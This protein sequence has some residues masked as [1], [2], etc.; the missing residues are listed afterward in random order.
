MLI[1]EIGGVNIK[2]DTFAVAPAVKELYRAGGAITVGSAVVMDT[3]ANLGSQVII[4]PAYTADLAGQSANA[5]FAG[6][7]TGTGGSGA[8]SVIANLVGKAAVAGDMILVVQR[9]LVYGVANAAIATAGTALRIGSTSG[10]MGPITYVA[11]VASRCNAVAL[12]TAA[13]AASVFRMSV[14]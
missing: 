7:Y 5:A 9:G 12:E 13:G 4:A 11:D 2:D 6:I 14:Q 1:N 3:A 8:A 10:R